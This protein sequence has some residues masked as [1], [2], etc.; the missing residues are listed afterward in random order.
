[1][2][3]YNA[4][5]YLERCVNSLLCQSF[6]NIEILLI[7]D[8]SKDTSAAICDKLSSQDCRIKVFHKENGGVSSARNLGLGKASGTHICFVDADD[9]VGPSYIENFVEGLNN[10]MELVFQGINLLRNGIIEERCPISGRYVGNDILN[11]I[12]DINRFSMF[13]FVCNKLYRTDIIRKNKLL[14]DTSITLSEDRIFALQY[15]KHIEC[16]VTISK[17][18]Y[19]Y[20]IQQGGL[21]N[22][23]R[24]Y[25]EL[26]AAA[27]AN[28]N[29]ALDLLQKWDSPRFQDDTRRMYVMSS[30]DY[31]RSLFLSENNS[32][33]T[34]QRYGYYYKAYRKWQSYYTPDDRMHKI[35]QTIIRIPVLFV[36]RYL[37]R[38]Y[39]QGKK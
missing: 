16:L 22:R 33:I 7:N 28:L 10:G 38:I 32:T 20:E 19:I 15:I 23:W 5:L 18:S 11:G 17:S 27:D 30:Y 31:I 12:S 21:T 24:S 34:N 29:A 9:Y 8:G 6:S 1:M 2:P 35:M 13:G 4:A 39:M 26:K 3:V 14:F 25:D 37:M 36:S